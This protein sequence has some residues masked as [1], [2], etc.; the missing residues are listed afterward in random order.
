MSSHKKTDSGVAKWRRQLQLSCDPHSISVFL[1]TIRPDQPHQELMSSLV[2][3]DSKLF[4]SVK[5]RGQELLE[6]W[7][8]TQY[9]SSYFDVPSCCFP[10]LQLFWHQRWIQLNFQSNW[11][12]LNFLPKHST[13][14]LVSKIFCILLYQCTLHRLCT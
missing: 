10:L 12:G 4:Q 9:W 3:L 7:S 13:S 11:F 8:S 14:R 1:W 5:K 2:P 6:L